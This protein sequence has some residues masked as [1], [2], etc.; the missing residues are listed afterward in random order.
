MGEFEVAIRA[1]SFMMAVTALSLPSMIMLKKVVQTPL[2]LLFFGI[3]SI[4]IMLIG[5]LFQFL[6]PMLG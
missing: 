5:V 2:L 1:M 4:G 6:G 3:V